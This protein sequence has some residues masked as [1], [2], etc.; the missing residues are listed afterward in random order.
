MD[1][2]EYISSGKLE[3]YVGGEL[4]DE[5]M[6]EVDQLASNNPTIQNELEEIRVG[7][8]AF[9][10]TFSKQPPISIL[11]S[12]LETIDEEK[13]EV[14]ESSSKVRQFTPDQSEN[15]SKSFPYWSVAASILLVISVALNFFYYSQLEET[16]DQIAS[17][18]QERSV[19]ADRVETTNQELDYAELRIAHFLNDDNI[20]VRMDG[21]PISPGSFANVFWN[22]NTNAVFISVDNLP[23]PPDGHQYQLWAIKS[24]E[25][26][27]DAGIFDHNKLVQELKIIK[28]DVLAFAV[29]LEKEGGTQF[30]TVDRTFVKGF[31]K[32]S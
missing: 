28:G 7:I 9:A 24:G 15:D 31:L 30:A 22:K 16:R 32:N 12:V 13:I 21:E 14:D 2:K 23:A 18:T 27:I 1:I 11:D 26:P 17:L 5:E 25:A 29:T 3:A 4:S 10:N 8:N 6:L 20:H 19:L